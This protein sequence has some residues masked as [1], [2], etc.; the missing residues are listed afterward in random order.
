VEDALDSVIMTALNKGIEVVCV[1]DPRMPPK[2]RG[3][4][5]RLKQVVLNLLSVGPVTNCSKRPS[6]R[7]I[8]PRVLTSMRPCDV[9]SI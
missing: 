1:I 9:L 6:T 7:F 8:H 2:V 3:D 5:D 4:G